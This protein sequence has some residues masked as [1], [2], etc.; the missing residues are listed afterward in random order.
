MI[1]QYVLERADELRSS[2]QGASPFRH[3]C[4]D[5]FFEDDVAKNALRDF[6][7]FDRNKAK[8]EFGQVGGKAITPRLAEISEFYKHLYEYIFSS[9][10]L[11]AMSAITGIPDLIGD[12]T[13]YGGGTHEN[14]NGQELD[15]HVD[16]NYING[17]AAH[18][19]AN[20]LIYLNENWKP[21]WG[22]QI[23]LHSNPRDP[24]KNKIAAFNVD[25]NR[26][27]IF[28][29][30]E[31][32][33]HGFPK[34]RLPPAEAGRSRKCISIYLY[35]RTRPAEEIAGPHGTF[36]VS[37]PISK[38]FT[39]GLRLTSED[40]AELHTA[41]RVRDKWIERYQIKEEVDGRQRV[42]VINELAAAR[43]NAKV[44]L[45]GYVLQRAVIVGMF[46]PD[47]W[48][49]QH[50]EVEVLAVESLSKITV[51]G[52]FPA[53]ERIGDQT[54]TVSAGEVSQTFSVASIKPTSFEMAVSIQA[55][56]VFRLKLQS[57]H[58]FS[59]AKLGT[60]ADVRELSY[61]IQSI[62]FD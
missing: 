56:Q 7:Q 37:R 18:R 23:E 29:T 40:A 3:L 32:S 16:F 53:T 62:R 46:H 13:M 61:R 20:L 14:L 55:G 43:R 44:P 45:L 10:F 52:D 26:A 17:G 54:L 36:Y 27:V 4:I 31:I 8:N 22:G 6:P 48:V 11:S 2:F 47:N 30:N 51:S 21:Q 1:S 58:A 24:Q 15:P 42:S 9:E 49:A 25:F 34:V 35:T 28:E 50:L 33:W 38:R 59:P 19:R 39:K 57:D 41:V 5:N 12:P 60:G